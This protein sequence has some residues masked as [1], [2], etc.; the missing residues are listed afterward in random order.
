MKILLILVALCFGLNDTSFIVDDTTFHYRKGEGYY[1]ELT[2]ADGRYFWQAICPSL[3]NWERRDQKKL[4]DL[5]VPIRYLELE[6]MPKLKINTWDLYHH[7][8]DSIKSAGLFCTETLRQVTYF[9]SCAIIETWA[10]L[11]LEKDFRNR[12]KYTWQIFNRLYKRLDYLDWYLLAKIYNQ[13]FHE[14]K[15]VRRTNVYQLF[16]TLDWEYEGEYPCALF[17]DAE[18]KTHIIM[19]PTVHPYQWAAGMQ[20]LNKAMFGSCIIKGDVE[21][22]PCTMNGRGLVM[23]KMERFSKE[24]AIKRKRLLIRDPYSTVPLTIPYKVKNWRRQND[25]LVRYL[26]RRTK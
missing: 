14:P 5:Y 2:G 1:Y 25:W 20:N 16:T 3:G 15:R 17:Y 6:G 10:S 21:I 13:R 26:K 4:R 19:L 18:Q 22:V 24:D 9:D 12:L 23:Q 7:V 8:L 11:D